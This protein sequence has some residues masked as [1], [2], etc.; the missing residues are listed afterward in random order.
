[1]AY[2]EGEQQLRRR[3]YDRNP[4][5][6]I[7]RSSV[8]FDRKTTHKDQPDLKDSQLNSPETLWD[9]EIEK[10]S[11]GTG[12][13]SSTRRRRRRRDVDKSFD[14]NQN[15]ISSIST[16]GILVKSFQAADNT[17]DYLFVLNVRESE[18]YPPLYL[19]EDVDC[20]ENKMRNYPSNLINKSNNL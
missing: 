1:M 10:E 9:L 11:E 12:D 19:A 17:I 16:T 14:G 3:M 7:R 8:N 4:N 20:V 18:N 6:G 2:D 5:R 15:L 13:D